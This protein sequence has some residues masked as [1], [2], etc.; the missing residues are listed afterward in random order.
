MSQAH[1]PSVHSSP[2][3]QNP[4]KYDNDN[5][6]YYLLQNN[7]IVDDWIGDNI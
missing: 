1:D 3:F 7:I 4:S 5:I 6:T 2:S